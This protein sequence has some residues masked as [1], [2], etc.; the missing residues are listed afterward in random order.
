MVSWIDSNR[1]LVFRKDKF[2]LSVL[3]THIRYPW[4]STVA[5]ESNDFRGMALVYAADE[6][7]IYVP[8]NN[9]LG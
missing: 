1:R 7:W 4:I 9:P 3:L 2:L 5:W 6:G 8:I